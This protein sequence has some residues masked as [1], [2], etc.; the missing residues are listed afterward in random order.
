MD[1]KKENVILVAKE[2]FAKKGLTTYSVQDIIESSNISKGTFYNYFSSKDEFFIAY[3]QYASREEKLRRESL[4]EG[5]QR[6]D[7]N[8][9]AKQIHVRIEVTREFTL[10]P[11]FEM[12]F[13]SKNIDLKQF[14]ERHF[15][16]ELKWIAERL[17]DIYG[18]HSRIYAE[19][20]AVLIHGMMQNLFH[21][22]KMLAK[23]RVDSMAIVHYILR[24]IDGVMKSKLV[25]D[26]AFLFEQGIS[27]FPRE[28][29]ILS[30]QQMIEELRQL[31]AQVHDRQVEIHEQ[32][33][34]LI[35]ELQGDTLRIY[36]IKPIIHA[37]SQIF[38][39][40]PYAKD[41]LYVYNQMID[42]I[43]TLE[44]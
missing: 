42:Y 18:A 40:T 34:F 39:N 37:L 24:E 6:N 13:Y 32:L 35:E 41:Y 8:I 30:H 11:I 3:L 4:L 14:T 23:K 22:L 9:L 10:F 44:E 15:L 28:S 2:L 26:E 17:M 20:C 43:Y 7:R 21:T 12:A 29:K 31:Q 36:I 19:D 27:L 25:N 33:A 16:E 38:A 5:M 1:T